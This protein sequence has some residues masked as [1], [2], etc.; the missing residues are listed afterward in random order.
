MSRGQ[1]QNSI[2]KYLSTL[3]QKPFFYVEIIKDLIFDKCKFCEKWDFENV[4]FVKK[5]MIFWK[6]EFC[7]ECDFE[8]V[9]F[10]RNWGFLPQCAV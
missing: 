5:K 2:S 10:W 9:N 6:C 1:N 8:F 4:I 3:G 7:E